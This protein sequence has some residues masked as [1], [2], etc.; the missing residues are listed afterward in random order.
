MMPARDVGFLSSLLTTFM[1]I[2]YLTD[3]ECGVDHPVQHVDKQ[4]AATRI[5]P[6]TI[7]TPR[8]ETTSSDR[9]DW[10]IKEPMPGQLNTVS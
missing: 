8:T 6:A 5:T 7:V 3:N 2:P 1:A 9:A 10:A 4:V